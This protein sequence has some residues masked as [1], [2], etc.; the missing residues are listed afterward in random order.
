M[1][2]TEEELN[3][4]IADAVAEAKKGL[5]SQEDF[6]KAISKRITEVNEKHKK[7]LEEKEKIAKMS[8]EEK[9]KH[10]FEQLTKERD[11]LKSSL[12]AK[13]HKEKLI[14]LMSE[15][16]VD[17]SFYD[18]FS[19]VQDLKIAGDM[20]DKFNESFNNKVNAEVEK[21]IKPNVP[22]TGGN[23]SDDQAIRK[24]MGLS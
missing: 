5:L 11:E 8:A 22:G 15:K 16:K 1:E 19:N 21:K 12:Q 10:D 20:M 18:V 13:E 4:K 24:A 2:I 6:D 9:Q 14:N 23:N 17:S 7:E 3:K